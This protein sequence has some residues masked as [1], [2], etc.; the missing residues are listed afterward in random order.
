MD[1]FGC[2]AW[3]RGSTQAFLKCIG[4]SVVK[5]IVRY[6]TY[7]YLAMQCCCF[8]GSSNSLQSIILAPENDLPYDCPFS[9]RHKSD[10]RWGGGRGR[11]D[12]SQELQGDW[13]GEGGGEETR[14]EI[15]K[16]SPIYVFIVFPRICTLYPPCYGGRY[17]FR[18]IRRI[19]IVIFLLHYLQ[20]K[21]LSLSGPLDQ[22]DALM[23][24]LDQIPE[25]HIRTLSVT[26]YTYIC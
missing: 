6:T 18:E 10:H 9:L 23:L 15:C 16:N 12:S 1:G 26:K 4:V 13:G 21:L 11:S 3:C 2:G 14:T 24:I 7:T 25:T 8:H 17:L 19:L 20:L 22:N 5:W